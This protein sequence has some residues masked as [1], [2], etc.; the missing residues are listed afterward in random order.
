M[1]MKFHVRGNKNGIYAGVCNDTNLEFV[2]KEE[3]TEEALGAT[4]KYMVS[5]ML[6]PKKN[7]GFEKNEAATYWL[8]NDGTAIEL[9]VKAFKND[10]TQK[11]SKK[12]QAR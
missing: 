5:S 9:Q 6:K 12:N 7:G 1:N 4:M 3:V 2:R 8:M 10:V 11:L